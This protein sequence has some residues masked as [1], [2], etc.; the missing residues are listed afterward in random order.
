[1]YK[2]FAI[3][4]LVLAFLQNAHAGPANN[5]APIKLRLGHIG[6]PGSLY[7]LTAAEFAKRVSEKLQGKVVVTVFPD[8]I[9]G[10]DPQMLDKV[11]LG[12][13]DFCMPAPAT[14]A[15]SPVFSVFDVPYLVLT[16]EHVRASRQ[17]LI[18]MYFQPAAGAKG[19]LVLGMWEN[20]FRHITNNVRPIHTPRDLKG[21]KIRVPQGSR[22]LT[23]LKSYG[24][25]PGEYPFGQPLVEALRNGTF[26]GQE[27]P[28]T[29]IRSL[30]MDRVQ[31]YLSLTH[32]TYMPVYLMGNEKKMA[33]LPPDVQAVIKRT[34]EDL[35]DW[36]MSAGEKLDIELRDQLSGTVAINEVDT[37]AFLAASFPA[38]TQ[39][40]AEVPQGKA[41][42]RLLYDRTSLAA[43][44]HTWQ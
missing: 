14:A 15:I 10:N 23:V 28:F 29:M 43:T 7:D 9:L 39:F 24:A 44:G 33:A 31:K 37:L 38:Y 19:L 22:F 17:K 1:M 40:A 25:A 32:H 18:Q 34:A 3:A 42:I 13:L 4:F 16:R 8:S 2:F 20:G 27:N 26:D 12:E 11:T 35:Q 30:K 5:A 36:S 41:L 6:S 21:L